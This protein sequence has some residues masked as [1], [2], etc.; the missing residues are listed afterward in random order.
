MKA[1]AD[2]RT[3]Y[4]NFLYATVVDGE[5]PISVVSMLSRLSLDPWLEASRLAQLPRNQAIKSLS[6]NESV[7]L[8]DLQHCRSMHRFSVPPSY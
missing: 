4:D 2:R 6:T 3:A 7:S 8:T 5:L 1:L